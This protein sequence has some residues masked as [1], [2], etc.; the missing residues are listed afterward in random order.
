M[1]KRPRGMRPSSSPMNL[2]TR[3]ILCKKNSFQLLKR[4]RRYISRE[5]KDASLTEHFPHLIKK[6]FIRFFRLRLEIRRVT[7]LFQCSLFFGIQCLRRPH[8]NGD[9][10]IALFV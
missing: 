1:Q 9:E 8:V 10:L 4:Q 3:A 7:Y 6:A 2:T 5:E